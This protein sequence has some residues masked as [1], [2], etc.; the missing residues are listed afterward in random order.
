[1]RETD[2]L[3]QT[4][5]LTQS[6]RDRSRLTVV[7]SEIRITRHRQRMLPIVS[8]DPTVDELILS[9]QRR[10]IRGRILLFV[11]DNGECRYRYP[12]Q[13]DCRRVVLELVE[14]Q[15]R[16]CLRFELGHN[17]FSQRSAL[18]RP[19]GN[20]DSRLDSRVQSILRSE[21]GLLVVLSLSDRIV[22]KIVESSSL[23]D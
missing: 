23:Q 5:R 11:I 3:D 4:Q 22:E 8:L 19:A 13:L 21:N 1:M 12:A 20:F 10:R 6:H 17:Q 14:R 16:C 7:Q 18:Q 15:C 2:S 9:E